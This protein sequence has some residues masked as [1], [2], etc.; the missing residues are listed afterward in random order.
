MATIELTPE[1]EALAQRVAAA[2][3][4]SVPA[5]IQRALEAQADA[6][7]VDRRPA[8]R[9][10]TVDEMLAFGAEIAAMPILDPR[11]ANEIMEDLNTP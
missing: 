7:G 5:A 8:R 1:T 11:S 9:R 3:R 10:M 2:Q 6:V 4:L